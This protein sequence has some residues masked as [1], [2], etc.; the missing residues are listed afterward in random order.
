VLITGINGFV[1]TQLAGHL[2]AFGWDVFVFDMRAGGVKIRSFQ[3]GITDRVALKLAFDEVKPDVIYHL[4][5]VI[6][7]DVADLLSAWYD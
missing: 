2:T 3:G 6:K 5:G 7:S 4:A 1:G